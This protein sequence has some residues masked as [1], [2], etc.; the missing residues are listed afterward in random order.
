MR[1]SS[2]GRRANQI[3]SSASESPATSVSM[4]AASATSTR[5]FVST[6]TTAS[7]II[8][9]A[10][11]A[12]T[13]RSRS[14]CSLPAVG[15]TCGIAIS[16]SPQD[17]SEDAVL[18]PIARRS[19]YASGGVAEKFRSLSGVRVDPRPSDVAPPQ[20]HLRLSRRAVG[21]V[22]CGSPRNL[23]ERAQI[24][25]GVEDAGPDVAAFAQALRH[26]V[27]VEV[28][29]VDVRQFLPRDGRGDGGLRRGPGG[30]L[31]RPASCRALFW[32]WSKKILPVRFGIA[33]SIV[34]RLRVLPASGTG[35]RLPSPARISS[36]VYCR[37]TGTKMCSPVLP[38]V[39]TNDDS[40]SCCSSSFSANA[41]SRVF[42]NAWRFSAGSSPFFSCPA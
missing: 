3:A 12:S 32:L 30:I 26:R 15:C 7:T 17:E 9:A 35:R 29:R 11:N 33:H 6:P 2:A 21:C 4:C 39:F 25:L 22:I 34:D 23:E 42:S 19:G 13:R 28:G 38:V 41:T 24:L 8:N 14:L 1:F 31:G 37:S 5:L 18:A 16:L 40:R 27:D 36:Y 20:D 10:V